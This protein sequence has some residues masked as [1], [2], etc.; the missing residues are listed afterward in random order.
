MK[1]R[2][3][4]AD[5]ISKRVLDAVGTDTPPPE[6]R[7]ELAARG[8]ALTKLGEDVVYTQYQW[9]DPALCRP[10]AVNARDYAAL[11]YD[12]CAELIETI[13]SEGKQRVP[14]I[15]R[16]TDDPETPYEVVAGLRRHWAIS[17][18]RA[19][20]FPDFKY[21]I[22]IQRLDDESAFR[23]SDLENR[24]RTDI[25][26]LERG[27]SYKEAL[28]TYYG[29]NFQTMAD[30]IGLTTRNLRRY[31]QLAD[32]DQVI[33]DALGGHRAV[34]TRHGEAIK[35]DLNRSALHAER[36]LAE[37]HEIASEQASKVGAGE[38][39]IPAAD[40]VRLLSK[41]A[42]A[43]PTRNPQNAAAPIKIDSADGKPMIE[44]VPGNRRTAATIKV[45]PKTSASRDELRDALLKLVDQVFDARS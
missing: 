19:H 10:S 36:L 16:P 38:A 18:L 2:S 7:Q 12:D 35:A 40:V 9:I 42:N 44:F 5:N 1:K 14:A 24:A 37:A 21:L 8:A 3:D 23:F 11:T 4:Y 41:A 31:V 25:T 33:I 27:R 34:S 28:A 20:N 43:K 26:D 39:L 32:L 22:H 30:R 6:E 13:K 45:L 15:V 29:G 17:W